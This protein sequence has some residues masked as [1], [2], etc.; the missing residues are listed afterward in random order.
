MISWNVL[1]R[2]RELSLWSRAFQQESDESRSGC[3][4]V[5]PLSGCRDFVGSLEAE[6][7]S[8]NKRR[9]SHYA[10]RKLTQLGT[11]IAMIPLFCLCAPFAADLLNAVAGNSQL[12]NAQEIVQLFCTI[13][14][15]SECMMLLNARGQAGEG[16]GRRAEEGSGVLVVMLS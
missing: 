1:E 3:V 10:G 12:M 8:P 14:G 9:K 2:V 16:S 6:P 11:P 7:G 4:S 5:V 13:G 15:L